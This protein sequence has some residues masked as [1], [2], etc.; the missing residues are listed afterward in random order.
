MSRTLLQLTPKLGVDLGQAT[1]RCW[2]DGKGLVLSEASCLAIDK[3]TGALVAIGNQAAELSDRLGKAVTVEWLLQDGVI[4]DVSLAKLYLQHVL[5]K[6]LPLR[7]LSPDILLSLP[8][9]TLPS[10]E[11]LLVKMWHE[12]GAREV[13][14]VN[15]PLAAAIG[16]GIPVADSS[17]ALVA[18][19]GA[20]VIEVACI[21]LGNQVATR[22]SYRA[23]DYVDQA[24]QASLQQQQHLLVSA[25]VARLL[26]ETVASLQ[27]KPRGKSVTGK[28]VLS[29]APQELVVKS[30]MLQEPT[31]FL[32]QEVAELAKQV[33]RDID[34]AVMVDVVAKGLLL[35]GG[36]AQLQGLDGYLAQRLGIP[37]AVVNEPAEATVKGLGRVLADYSAFKQSL[38]YRMMG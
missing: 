9:Q 38:A 18:N 28:S 37:V 10:V 30:V 33:L 17:G 20:G 24:I 5:A 27:K 25:Q 23:G 12:L 32:A 29:G 14:V 11:S 1:T 15:Q 22:S 35:T 6:A 4:K 8:T 3:R 36:L 2:L 19:I 21:V 13:G 7:F 26:K 31:M 16:A 34:P